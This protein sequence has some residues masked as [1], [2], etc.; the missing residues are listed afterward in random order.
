MV[1]DKGSIESYRQLFPVTRKLAYLNHAA[2]GAPSTRA[3]EAISQ[4]LSDVSLQGVGAVPA[5][6]EQRERVRR[7]MAKFVGARAGEIA[8]VKNTPEAIGIVAAGMRWRP[9]D[10]VIV[11]DLEFPANVFP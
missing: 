1:I 3:L 4:H 8:L 11:S 9:G 7:K 5:C 6:E 2:F 10:R